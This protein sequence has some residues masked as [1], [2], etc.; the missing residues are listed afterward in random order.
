MIS[1]KQEKLLS[2]L[3]YGKLSLLKMHGAAQ[4]KERQLTDL[5]VWSVIASYITV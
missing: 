1:L 4:T 2:V 5:V 3:H